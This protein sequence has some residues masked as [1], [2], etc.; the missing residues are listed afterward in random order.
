MVAPVA[1]TAG[2]WLNLGTVDS[3]AEVAANDSRF[4]QFAPFRSGAL[5]NNTRRTNDIRSNDYWES[6]IANPQLILA[7]LIRIVHPGLLPKDSL[8]YYKQLK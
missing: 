7:D 8:Y 2:Y 6:G 5:Y 4:T 3:K 1:L